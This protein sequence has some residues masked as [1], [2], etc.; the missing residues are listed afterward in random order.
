MIMQG[1]L[2]SQVRCVTSDDPY[3]TPSKV[4][5]RGS[6]GI[7]GKASDWSNEFLEGIYQIVDLVKRQTSYRLHQNQR[8]YGFQFTIPLTECH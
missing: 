3:T 2:P 6:N 7:E 8:I 5:V 1:M 4:D